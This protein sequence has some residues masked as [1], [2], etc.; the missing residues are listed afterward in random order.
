[1]SHGAAVTYDLD[2]DVPRAGEELF[3]ID[4]ATA[5]RGRRLGLAPRVGVVEVGVVSDES[6]P[7]SATA[8]ARLDDHL[9]ARTERHQKEA[10]VF[11]CRGAERTAQYRHAETLRERSRPA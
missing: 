4:I 3:D 11:E 10:R 9:T 1:M 2:L 6:Y 7:P 5:E 8:G